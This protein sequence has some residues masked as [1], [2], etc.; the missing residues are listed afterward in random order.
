ML[1]IIIPMGGEDEKGRRLKNLYETLRCIEYQT[2]SDYEVVLVE[3]I[4]R[5]NII[6]DVVEVDQ[7]IPVKASRSSNRSWT[8]NVGVQASHGEKLLQLDGDILFGK[9][10]FQRIIDHPHEW[11][12][13]WSTCYRL[14]PEGFND[15]NLNEDLTTLHKYSDPYF[16]VIHSKQGGACGFS[17]CF[18]RQFYLNSLGGYNENFTGWGGEDDDIAIRAT[19]ILGNFYTLPY[20][21]YHL[22]HSNRHGSNREIKKTISDPQG[23]TERLKKAKLGRVEGATR[24]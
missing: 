21:I 16:G 15:W 12:I 1:S 23:V 10:Y 7:Y 2:Y 6:F 3:E 17:S 5:G 11:F 22:P 20:I 14:T 8:R 18:N 19:Q 4:Y 24:I 9:D 13:G